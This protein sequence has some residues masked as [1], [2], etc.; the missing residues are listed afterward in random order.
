VRGARAALALDVARWVAAVALAL[1]AVS[2]QTDAF[3]AWRK[4]SFHLGTASGMFHYYGALL[5]LPV[6]APAFASAALLCPVV[7]R[8]ALPARWA[9]GRLLWKRFPTVSPSEAAGAALLALAVLA[10]FLGP[11]R[12]SYLR[13][14]LTLKGVA[15][16]TGLGAVP[17]LTALMIPANAGEAVVRWLGVPPEHAVA[18]HRWLGFSVILML[19]LHGGGYILAWAKQEGS[20]A[21]YSRLLTAKHC[22]PRSSICISAG[23]FAVVVGLVMGLAALAVVRRRSW[24]VFRASHVLGAPLFFLGACAHWPSFVWWLMPSLALHF[25]KVAERICQGLYRVPALAAIEAAGRSPAGTR[26]SVRLKLPQLRGHVQPGQ[27]IG[28]GLPGLLSEN[29]PCTLISRPGAHHAEVLLL[30]NSKS[31]LARDVARQAAFSNGYWAPQY[32]RVR[33]PYGGLTPLDHASP[34]LLVAGGSG[35]TTVLGLLANDGG[36]HHASRHLC[37]AVRGDV[38]LLRAVKAHITSE[39]LGASVTVHATADYDALRQEM[40]DDPLAPMRDS[41]RET[42]QEAAMSGALKVPV[43]PAEVSPL[44]ANGAAC[45]GVALA[46]LF[47]GGWVQNI[48]VSTGRW[49]TGPALL[50]VSCAASLGTAVIAV[51]S[52]R[53]MAGSRSFAKRDPSEKDSGEFEAQRDAEAM[54]FAN[55]HGVAGNVNQP[56]FGVRVERGRP[57][58]AEELDRLAALLLPGSHLDVIT[59]GPEGLVTDLRRAC[60]VH[61]CAARIRFKACSF[62]L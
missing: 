34:T 35:I 46:M 48:K 38:A 47:S 40:V 1:L 23:F 3:R 61:P 6:W 17:L 36:Q 41:L 29:H 28:V 51:Y 16:S 2:M 13:K 15:L 59:S 10:W 26:K 4:R 33:G 56:R 52:A 57:K 11:L 22:T 31:S 25:A 54:P 24:R 50:L 42:E 5:W 21:V 12:R 27:W 8:G 37:W 7:M 30:L 45:F 32:L 49:A 55:G 60:V 9:S 39:Q 62:T 53:L 44:L 14:G 18:Y 20:S 58:W 43:A 19:S